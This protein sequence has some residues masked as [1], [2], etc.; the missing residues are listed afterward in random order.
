LRIKLGWQAETDIQP[1]NFEL[2]VMLLRRFKLEI[3]LL[4]TQDDEEGTAAH[5]TRY[6][7]VFIHFNCNFNMLIYIY[8]IYAVQ[9]GDRPAGDTGR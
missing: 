7:G 1:L 5:V 4:G 3:A 6:Q 2:Y 9:A 8:Y